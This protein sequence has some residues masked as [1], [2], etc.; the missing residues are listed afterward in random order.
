ML[1]VSAQPMPTAWPDAVDFY[2]NMRMLIPTI[3]ATHIQ[4]VIV[5]HH[6]WQESDCKGWKH[7]NPSHVRTNRQDGM[8]AAH[9]V[10]G[11]GFAH[12]LLTTEE[13]LAPLPST[14][15]EET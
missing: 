12:A 3:R 7:L 15:G 4:V 6:R 9:E 2:D 5:P 13:L 14:R 11:P 8:H 10:N 1:L